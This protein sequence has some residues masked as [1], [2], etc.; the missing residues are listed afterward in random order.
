LASPDYAIAYKDIPQGTPVTIVEKSKIFG[1][2][3]LPGNRNI[4]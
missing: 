3:I 4:S 2:S 1:N